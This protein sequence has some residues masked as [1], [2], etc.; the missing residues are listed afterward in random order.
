MTGKERILTTLA[1]G[2]PDRVPFVPNPDHKPEPS[3]RAKGKT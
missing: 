2:I 3:T 1:G